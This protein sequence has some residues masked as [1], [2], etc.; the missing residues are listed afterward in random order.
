MRHLILCPL[1]LAAFDLATI[2]SF[3][4]QP[5][6]LD[7]AT[8]QSRHF[9]LPPPPD[10][11]FVIEGTVDPVTSAGGE[12]QA[13]ASIVL[14]WPGDTPPQPRSRQQ[15]CVNFEIREGSGIGSWEVWIDGI[16]ET[17][18]EPRPE[19]AGWAKRG[20][21][22][23]PNLFRQRDGAYPVR[24]VGLPR[25]GGTLLQFFFDHLDRPVAEHLVR[26]H[27]ADRPVI[28]HAL[29]GGNKPAQIRAEFD[30][31]IRSLD[32]DEPVT[33]PSA[34]DIVLAALDLEHPALVRVAEAIAADDKPTAAQ[35]FLD[36]MRTRKQPLG[37]SLDEFGELGNHLEIASEV[38]AGRYGTVGWFSQFASQWTDANGTVHPW[39]LENGSVNWAREN[40]HLNRHFHWVSL[41]FAHRETSEPA[42]AKRCAFEIQDWV[43]GEPFYWPRCPQ[44]GNINLMDGTVFTKGYM[45]TSNIGRRCEL[46][47]WYVWE[48][49]RSCPDFDD[50]ACFAMLLGFLRQ[51][52]LLMNPSSFAAH[53]D[54][55]AH[56]SMSL[57]QN[58]LMLPEFRESKAWMETALRQWDEVLKVQFHPDGSHVSGS[59]GYNW[60]S[61]MALENLHALAKRTGS[62][63]PKRFTETLALSLRHPIGI[64]RPDQGQIDMNDGG[65]SM[66]DD[67]YRRVVDRI[68]PDREVFQWMASRAESGSPPGY[69]SIQFPHAGHLVQRTG[70]GEQHKYLFMDAGPMGASHGKNDK[71]NVYFAIGPHQLIASGG[72]GSYDANP[73]SAYAGSTYGYN[74]ILVDDLPQQ[75]IHLPHTHTGHLP[76]QRRW[77]T[78]ERFDYA[79]G[80]YRSGWYGSKHKVE[81]AHA[82]E[83]I[84]VK[85]DQPPESSYWI[86]V[87]TIEPADEDEH[88]Y[89][90]LFHSRRDAA[91]IDTNNKAFTAVDRAAGFR[92]LPGNSA[93]LSVRDARG[94]MQ[95]YIQG[96]HVV[97]RNRAPMH[98]AEYSWNASGPTTRVW[99]LEA[100][101]SPA[102]WNVQNWT[103]N[104]SD[105]S[106]TLTIERVDGSTDQL[107]RVM[108]KQ[109]SRLLIVSQHAD[110]SESARLEVPA[111]IK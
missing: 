5:V 55:G 106:F 110:G 19:P 28:A 24:I 54:G 43:G 32:S 65:W 21:Y 75:R 92:I 77:I 1:L 105:G 94:Q 74:T 66:V 27:I 98:T 109:G 107:T 51:S 60:A 45:N 89:K 80:F 4:S 33:T 100:T 111:P 64:S 96:W 7:P 35:L 30:L 41:A 38:L 23:L 73:F 2:H 62:E 57:L 104:G 44:V 59:T 108:E 97:G 31:T 56:S 42:Y 99:I 90:A 52:R 39:I 81:G 3:A 10:S 40:G 72:R 87:D 86:V 26:H 20:K 76:E 88:A 93:G 12:L 17:T 91:E 14:G 36:H 6:H 61:I 47:W 84:F 49:F 16:N 83:V 46:V 71:L 48:A 67:H 101:L 22:Q 50:D 63:L 37:P 13:V 9:V 79:E 25:D 58:G 34:R 11:P 78:S 15:P 29:L 8:G 70:W 102:K 69:L 103:Q 82:R 18:R 85:G 68:F 53:D 95:P